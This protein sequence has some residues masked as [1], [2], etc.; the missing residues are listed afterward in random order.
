MRKL[1]LTK[2]IHPR[3]LPPMGTP[4]HWDAI[5]GKRPATEV[6]WYRPHLERS[7]RF[8]EQ[9]RLRADA[10]MLDGGGGASTL[11]GDL[12]DRGFTNLHALALAA[13]GGRGRPVAGWAWPGSRR[14]DLDRRGRHAGGTARTPV[15]LL[16]RSGGLP[17]SRRGVLPRP[18][19]PGRSKRAQARRAH[20][21]GDI[22]PLG[23]RAL[24]RPAG[25]PLPPRGHSRAVRRAVPQGG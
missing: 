3:M 9:A 4:E 14:G 13:G 1:G 18:L 22:R 24:P 17:F 20:R 23:A 16:A 10:A 12:L 6:S 7:L 21:G 8:V 19:R 2:G 5:Y 15:R 25:G 11:V